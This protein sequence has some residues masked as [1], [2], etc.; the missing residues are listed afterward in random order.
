MGRKIA[1][2]AA[3][4]VLGL[5]LFGVVFSVWMVFGADPSKDP[6]LSW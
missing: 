6:L 3:G 5:L 2:L 1:A 4:A